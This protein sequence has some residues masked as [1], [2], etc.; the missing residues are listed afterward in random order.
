MR[1]DDDNDLVDGSVEVVLTDAERPVDFEIG[2]DGD[3][4]YLTSGGKLWH[5]RYIGSVGGSDSSGANIGIVVAIAAVAVAVAAGAM[6]VI[7]RRR[8]A[9]S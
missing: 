2:P 1:V 8:Q 6:V 3:I 5:L 9:A 7:T 4:Y